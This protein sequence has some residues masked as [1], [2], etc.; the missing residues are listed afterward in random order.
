M[1]TNSLSRR[2]FVKDTGVLF[3]G[4]SLAGPVPQA[5]RPAWV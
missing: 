5:M 1:S 2:D 3:V 4:V